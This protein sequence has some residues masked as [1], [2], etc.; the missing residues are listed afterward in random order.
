MKK[1]LVFLLLAALALS[2]ACLADWEPVTAITLYSG[3]GTN[4]SS[5]LGTMARGTY[6]QVEALA[7][8]RQG[9]IWAHFTFAGR[10]GRLYM[11]YAPISRLQVP[12][13]GISHYEFEDVPY[14]DLAVKENTYVYY[15][16][17]MRGV[18]E[19]EYMRRPG[20]LY[21]G[22]IVSVLG[23]MYDYFLVEYLEDGCNVRGYVL[24]DALEVIDPSDAYIYDN[25][26][27]YPSGAP[28][29]GSYGSGYWEPAPSGDPGSSG[30]SEYGDYPG[31]Y[32]QAGYYGY[33]A[34]NVFRARESRDIVRSYVYESSHLTNQWNDYRAEYAFDGLSSTDWVEG[35]EAKQLNDYVGCV[36]RV[37]DSRIAAYGISIKSGMQYKGFESWNR[38]QRPR[39]IAVTVN[40]NNYYFTLSDTMDEQTLYFN[41]NMIMPDAGGRLD[42]KVTVTDVYRTYNEDGEPVG[43][44]D[45]AIND[46]DLL[47]VYAR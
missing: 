7:Y 44:Y 32:G 46:I 40:G 19:L 16:P 33:P 15:G 26:N 45:I 28:D 11:A 3:P 17:Y 2:H 6:V 4:Y 20:M 25:G 30:Y 34:S 18:E 8:D 21:S 22:D 23:V 29:P 5:E 39:S 37:Y 27:S 42:L 31:Y 13:Y 9:S 14:L 1:T 10:N 36:W 35:S 47:C 41:G 24:S 43:R 38:N 12:D